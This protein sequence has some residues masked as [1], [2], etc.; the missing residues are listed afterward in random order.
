[1]DDCDLSRIVR[2]RPSDLWINH[3][4][5]VAKLD[6]TAAF[7]GFHFPFGNIVRGKEIQDY[8]VSISLES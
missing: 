5:T 8:P 2:I 1:M 7:I 6:G 3:Y 4:Q